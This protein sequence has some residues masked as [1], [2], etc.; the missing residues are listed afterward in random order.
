MKKSFT[1]LA[2]LFCAT[3]VTATFVSCDPNRGEEDVY[4]IPTDDGPD[5]ILLEEE[6]ANAS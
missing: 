4:V 2:L 3:F 5:T 6:P 1:I